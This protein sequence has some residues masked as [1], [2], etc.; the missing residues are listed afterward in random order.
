[1]I[2]G[3]EDVDACVEVEDTEEVLTEHVEDAERQ[4]VR[5][6]VEVRAVIFPVV[7]V[8]LRRALTY[9]G[10]DEE[11]EPEPDS[12][13]DGP[14]LK[15]GLGVSYEIKECE[16]DEQVGVPLEMDVL[17]GVLGEELREHGLGHLRAMELLLKGLVGRA[18]E[19][20]RTSVHYNL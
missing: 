14:D 6:V 18:L 8:V 4:Q 16:D 17:L 12:R 20:W 2:S 9:V 19:L 15:S 13:R 7:A 3:V 10:G 11:A 1:M 5:L